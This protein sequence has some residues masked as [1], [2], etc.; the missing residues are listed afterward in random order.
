[1]IIRPIELSDIGALQ[2]MR[3]QAEKRLGF[4]FNLPNLLVGV[5]GT[6]KINPLIANALVFVDD[7]EI[8]RMASILKKTT[9][10]YLLMDRTDK[11][12]HREWFSRF[13]CLEKASEQYAIQNGINE[14]ITFLSPE[15][16]K[17][18]G[19]VI[20]RTGWVREWPAWGKYHGK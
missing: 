13:L 4:E 14:T 9:E 7:N 1:M 16:A 15:L 17:T 6:A 3:E 10:S 2:L 5:N 19:R 20:E 11:V 18:W 12:G 8:P